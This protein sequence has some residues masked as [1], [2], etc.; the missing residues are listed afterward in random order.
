MINL[1][2]ILYTIPI[3]LCLLLVYRNIILKRQSSG[4]IKDLLQSE[5]DNDLLKKKMLQ[6]M[7]DKKL[8]ESEEFMMFL[9][10]SREAAFTYIEDAQAAIKK[11]DDDVKN[12][13]SSNENTIDTLMKILDANKELQ[14]L[15]PDNIKNNS[16]QGEL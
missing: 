6:T 12:A 10:K 7:E 14:K 15:L 11:F 8:V 13:L 5:A 16:V 1:I 3:L 4:F 9:T 2:D